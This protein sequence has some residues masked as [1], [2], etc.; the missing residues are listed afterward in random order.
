ML[1][2]ALGNCPGDIIS[3]KCSVKSYSPEV[4]LTWRITFPGLAP[5]A[6]TY[7]DSSSMDINVPNIL[8]MNITTTLTALNESYIQSV[9]MFTVTE[10]VTSREV[11]L[12]CLL[13]D[14]FNRSTP[15]YDLGK[16]SINVEK[17]RSK[18]FYARQSVK[19]QL[20]NK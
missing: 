3:Y 11:L 18:A 19:I 2:Q 12:E 1:P 13:S 5:L 9:I 4:E 6:V 10:N 14:Q 15:L 17:R 8:D 7:D 16:F 20:T